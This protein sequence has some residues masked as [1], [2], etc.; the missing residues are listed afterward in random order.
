LENRYAPQRCRVGD[1]RK[2]TEHLL[3]DEHKDGAPKSKFLKAFGFS[4]DRPDSLKE[5]LETHAVNNELVGTVHTEWGTKYV[6][7]CSIT[8]PDGRNPCI[9]TVWQREGNEGDPMLVTAV[10]RS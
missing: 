3:N 2:I 9:R 10:P 4:A 8:T 5:A 1:L 7:E 6:V